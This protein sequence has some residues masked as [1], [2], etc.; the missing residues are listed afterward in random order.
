MTVLQYLDEHVFALVAIV[1]YGQ[2]GL[3]F[4]LIQGFMR[5]TMPYLY[6]KLKEKRFRREKYSKLTVAL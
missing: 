1:K 3:V 5:I 6:I 2:F 4:S